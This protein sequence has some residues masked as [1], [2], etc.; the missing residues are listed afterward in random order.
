MYFWESREHLHLV[1]INGPCTTK[2][3]IYVMERDFSAW[4]VKYRV[5]L[6]VKECMMYETE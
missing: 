1:E 3:D 2:F 6:N 4:F 5:D